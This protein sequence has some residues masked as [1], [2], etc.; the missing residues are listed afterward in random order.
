MTSV[1]LRAKIDAMLPTDKQTKCCD[2]S[3]MLMATAAAAFRKLIVV[4]LLLDID[5]GLLYTGVVTL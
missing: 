5:L 4:Q 2:T 3:E 1:V